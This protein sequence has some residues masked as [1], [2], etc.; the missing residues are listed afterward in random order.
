[1]AD[2]DVNESVADE[3][4]AESEDSATGAT[5]K[6]GKRRAMA[7]LMRKEVRSVNAEARELEE[8]AEELEML[9]ALKHRKIDDLKRKL[10]QK[11]KF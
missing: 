3:D 8:E 5:S 2:E 9:A 6:M 1:M 4:V 7:A 10:E 11:G